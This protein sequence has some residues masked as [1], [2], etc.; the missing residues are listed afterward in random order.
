M[1][2]TVP[3]QTTKSSLGRSPIDITRSRF[4]ANLR[5]E[6]VFL[7]EDEETIG[8]S[9][10]GKREHFFS[11]ERRNAYRE[12]VISKRKQKKFTGRKLKNDEVSNTFAGREHEE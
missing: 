5:G 11:G 1:K 12:I 7:S 8:K 3:T 6:Y 10:V 4:D 2:E 9:N